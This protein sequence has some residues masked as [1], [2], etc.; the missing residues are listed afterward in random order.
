MKKITINIY[1]FITWIL[2]L[3]IFKIYYIPEYLRQGFKII[4]LIGV[5][6]FIISKSSKKKL[7]NVSLIYCFSVMLSAFLVYV[8]GKYNFKALLDSLLF[9]LTFYDLYSFIALS[10]EKNM[11]ALVLNTLYKITIL[12][13]VLTIISVIFVGVENNSNNAAYI[14]GNKFTSSYLFILLVSLYPATHK[15]DNITCKLFELFL[16][17]FATLFSLYLDCST[18]TVTLIVLLMYYYTSKKFKKKTINEKTVCIM[19]LCCGLIVISITKL[20]QID[21]INS[22]IF[23]IFDK[24][25]TV[26]G[27]VEIYENYLL[28]LLSQRFWTGFGYSSGE[29]LNISSG[30][31]ANAQNGLF[32]IMI[33]YGFIG[34]ITVLFTVYYCYFK[35][36]KDDRMVYL[37]IIV[38]GMTVASI[39]EVTI[40]WFFFLGLFLIR[41]NE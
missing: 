16:F 38:L 40:N 31:F 13:C 4:T 18:S 6:L 12:Y 3:S 27:R 15:M 22:I 35:A 23:D 26:F 14:F 17:I 11:Y 28:E 2:Y 7:I 37:S 8:E 10:K 21:I 25:Y 20:L 29:M 32:D 39:F 33:N 41:W 24:S 34:I 30:I 1:V 5:F 19:L 9:C 36:R